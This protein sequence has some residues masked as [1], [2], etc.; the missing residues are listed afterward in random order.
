MC[1]LLSRLWRR[2][3]LWKPHT[4]HRWLPFGLRLRLGWRWSVRKLMPLP[5]RLMW[6]LPVLSSHAMV[7]QLLLHL[8]LVREY[9]RLRLRLGYDWLLSGWRHW[10][11]RM[12]LS[13]RQLRLLRMRSGR[14]ILCLLRYL[15]RRM[16]QVVVLAHCRRLMMM[17]KVWTI[18]YGRACCRR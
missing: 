17:M 3:L 4:H 14:L 8:R 7:S 15:G 13:V 6:Q 11:L 12:L 2:W 1:L 18:L 9:R 5:R 10:R 16:Q